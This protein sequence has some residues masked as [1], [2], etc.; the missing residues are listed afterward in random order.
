MEGEQVWTII[1]VLAGLVQG[2]GVYIH[3]QDRKEIAELKAELKR[4]NEGDV[5]INLANADMAKKYVE[6]LSE[7]GKRL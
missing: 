3:R 7:L 4:R 1:V 6:L 5:A 2:M